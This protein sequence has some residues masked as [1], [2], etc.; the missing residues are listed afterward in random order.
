[1]DHSSDPAPTTVAAAPI[2]AIPSE[3][4][5][6]VDEPATDAQIAVLLTAFDLPGRPDLHDIDGGQM[7]TA[8]NRSLVINVPLRGTW[9]YA[10]LDAQ[11]LPAATNE[12]SE[13]AARS[14]LL[15]LGIDS[16]GQVPTFTPNGPSVDIALGDCT[17]RFANNGRP[18]WAIGSIAAIV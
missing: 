4:T 17:M 2:D 16:V 15:K 8:G 18:A 9:Q 5:A 11:D 14:L 7:V 12:E 3:S 1:M 6:P 13:A 10:D